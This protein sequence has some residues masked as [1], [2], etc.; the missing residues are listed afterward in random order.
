[1]DSRIAI[2]S[3]ETLQEVVNEAV[4]PRRF[5]ATLGLSFAFF[6]TFLAALGL[7]GVISLS[8]AQRTPEIGIRMALGARQADVLRMVIAKG[9]RVSLAGLAVGL[10]AAFPLTSLITSLLY[11]VKPTNPLLLAVVVLIL[12]GVAGLASLIPGRRATRVDPIVAL[13]HE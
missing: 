8:V 10:A 5:V 7:Y 2:P 1:L 4:A 3:E 13:R 11:G 12:G 6:A 9:L